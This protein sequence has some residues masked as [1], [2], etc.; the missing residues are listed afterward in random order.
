MSRP[1]DFMDEEDEEARL[2]RLRAIRTRR[3]NKETSRDIRIGKYK[4][5]KR[6]GGGNFSRVRYCYDDDGKA[7][8]MKIIGMSRLRDGHLHRQLMSEI[9]VLKTLDHRNIVKLVDVLKSGHHIYMVMELCDDGELLHLILKLRRFDERVARFYFHQLIAGVYHC[10]RYHFAHRDLKLEN[11]LLCKGGVVKI[12]DFGLST[13]QPPDNPLR[14]VCGTPNYVAPEVLS[15]RGYDGLKADM[16]SCGVILYVLLSGALPFEN[17]SLS[18]LLVI[19]SMGLYPSLSFVSPEAG[20][21]IRRLLTVKPSERISA[22]E[23]ISHPWFTVGFD[24]RTLM[25]THPREEVS[26]D[27]ESIDPGTV[28]ALIAL[29]EQEKE[30]IE[31]GTLDCNLNSAST[32]TSREAASAAA[33]ERRTETS[34]PRYLGGGGDQGRSAASATYSAAWSCGRGEE[35][36]VF[37]GEDREWVDEV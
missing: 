20:D 36:E 33:A 22:R 34:N 9:A 13:L 14:T 27:E 23:V 15:E 29:R 37:I 17:P 3:R 7:Y 30:L 16:W 1:I 4:L 5:G 11:L 28:N 12:T 10:H 26:D 31:S 25:R 2:L 6:I 24:P 35:E 21:L 32:R 8:A 19:I 18:K